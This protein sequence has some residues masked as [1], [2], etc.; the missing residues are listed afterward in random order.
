MPIILFFII[1]IGLILIVYFAGHFLIVTWGLTLCLLAVILLSWVILKLIVYRSYQ[2]IYLVLLSG[3]LLLSY[4]RPNGQVAINLN[5]YQYV[6][7]SQHQTLYPLDIVNQGLAKPK[8]SYQAVKDL[9]AF[10]LDPYSYYPD[11]SKR[12]HLLTQLRYQQAR[13]KANTRPASK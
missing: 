1:L 7:L 4:H 2:V 11:Q 12:K 13:L 8:L 3:L 9:Q 6:H 10:K 5:H